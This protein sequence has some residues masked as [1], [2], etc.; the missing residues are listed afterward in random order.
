MNKNIP[1]LLILFISIFSLS[2]HAVP[3]TVNYQGYLTTPDGSPIDE[4]VSIK[5]SLYDA[6]NAGT[7]KWTETQA[8]VVVSNGLLTV[9]LGSVTPF[10]TEQFDIPLWLGIK[11]GNDAEMSP[12][13]A[14]NSVVYAHKA[15]D[16]NTVNGLLAADLDQSSHVNN[17]ANPHQ[18]VIGQIPGALS[19]SDLSNHSSNSTAHHLKY[20]DSEA[21][22]AMG[23]K[24]SAN[25]LNH[26][27]TSTL[28]WNNITN[29]P[30]GFAD[31]TDNTGVNTV[32]A[33]A[34]LS[35]GGSTSSVTLNLQAPIDLTGSGSSVIK[36]A[37]ANGPT[38]GYLGVQGASSFEGISSLNISGLEI[39]VLGL[40]TGSS[41]S[42]NYGLY[43]YSNNIGLFAQ[44][45]IL[46]AKFV[47]D[48][49]VSNDIKV[50]G[51]LGIGVLPS[52]YKLSVKGGSSDYVGYFDNDNNSTGSAK[53]LYA[54]GDARTTGTG[55]GSGAYFYGYG[56]STSGN[57]S[58]SRN[59]AYAYG[60]SNAY[61]LYSNATGGTTT[62]IEYALYGVGKGYL[63][64]NVGIGL[65]PD[66]NFKLSV[67]GGSSYYVGHFDND[68]NATGS[69]HGVYARGD[70]RTTGTG[71]GYGAYFIG[72]GGNSSGKAYGSRHFAYAN[73]TSA[74][75][76]V[77]SDADGGST[78]GHEYAFYGLG[79]G[80]F[81]DKVGIGTNNPVTRLHIPHHLDA[82][83]TDG[84]GTVLI[85]VESGENIVMDNN[86][87]M[88]RNNGL[89]SKLFLN[90]DSTHVVVP[91]L[92]I[93]GGA[94]IAE[95]FNVSDQYKVIPGMV[96]SI[97]PE[98]PGQLRI[99][100]NSYDRTVAGIVS[101]AK[102]INP[103]VS[104]T[105]TGAEETQGS[106]P[107][108]LTG[109][110]Y[111]LADSQ[112]GEIKPGDLLTTS[113][114][115]GHV[116]KVSDY[117]KAQ[118]AIIGKAMTPLKKGKGHVLILVSLQ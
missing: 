53:G 8:A 89:P 57:A 16:A 14:L 4:S 34:G 118:G 32:I 27:Q 15:D 97:D 116:M 17:T 42:D 85:G 50:S 11:V 41:I 22:Q 29:K 12:L 28:P 56:G 63:S 26:D 45:S 66:D 25:P 73:G 76:G 67:K 81:S 23:A 44:G 61:G 96:M 114:T 103:G 87:I 55:A 59:Y 19:S 37:G 93:T 52:T 38:N 58:G 48:I 75:Y 90:R 74:A 101:G 20:T 117:S 77:Y 3:S 112:Y 65:F 99:A 102:G 107:I 1:T 30:S 18:V 111:A 33:G 36:G 39:G 100:N 105:Q 54:R 88:A 109:R 106:T 86:E 60:S 49:D 104:L 78:S 5:F 98:N 80:Y 6:K 64:D 46:A 91:G 84:S 24:T 113:N 62:G 115:A 21:R 94:D 47:G 70:A 68:N 40:S 69:A 95:P 79:K 35:G 71:A 2:V 7:L 92:E 10:T 108:A 31:G 13:Q 110:L 43:G 9:Q 72:Y 82:K 51:N 83:I